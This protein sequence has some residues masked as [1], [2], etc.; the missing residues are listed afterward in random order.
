M[1]ISPKGKA[2]IS[3][4]ALTL[5]LRTPLCTNVYCLTFPE[6]VCLCKKKCILMIHL[7][8]AQILQQVRI[9]YML[10]DTCIQCMLFL[11]H[12]YICIFQSLAF[13]LC[14]FAKDKK[15]ISCQQ[16][17]LYMQRCCTLWWRQLYTMVETTVHYGRDNCTPW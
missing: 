11:L 17:I 2:P 12:V 7:S 8:I 16:T 5:I 14:E 4:G 10:H 15:L 9:F 6:F 1:L 13:S 3:Y